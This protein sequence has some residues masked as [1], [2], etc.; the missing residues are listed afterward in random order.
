MGSDNLN[1]ITS[2]SMA[3]SFENLSKTAVV[4]GSE[5]PEVDGSEIFTYNAPQADEVDSE[6]EKMAIEIS[7]FRIVMAMTINTP[8]AERRIVE[9]RK[10]LSESCFDLNK[11]DIAI[12]QQLTI[13][14]VAEQFAA[15]LRPTTPEEEDKRMKILARVKKDGLDP[16]KIKKAVRRFV[17]KNQPPK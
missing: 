15:V 1:G 8:L 6:N 7:A 4:D 5:I 11:L 17:I 10:A 13:E 14:E 16:D 2:D 3:D 9:I 12:S